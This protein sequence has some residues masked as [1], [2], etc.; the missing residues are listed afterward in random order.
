MLHN[1]N[2]FNSLSM[3]DSFHNDANIVNTTVDVNQMTAT[4]N[5]HNI[6]RNQGTVSKGH[7]TSLKYDSPIQ[8]RLRNI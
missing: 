1:I 8:K 4:K 5:R 2:S 7:L 3:N 6:I